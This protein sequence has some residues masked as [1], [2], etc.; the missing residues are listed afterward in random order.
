MPRLC[1]MTESNPLLRQPSHIRRFLIVVAILAA[2]LFVAVIM[3]SRGRPEWTP[4]DR[5]TSDT[6]VPAEFDDGRRHFTPETLTAR[7]LA[8]IT[9]ASQPVAG[10]L[11]WRVGV[12]IADG[13]PLYYDWPTPRPGWYLNWT[14]VPVKRGGFWGL[15]QTSAVALPAASL[16]MEY[17]PMVRMRNGRLFPD[18]DQLRIL[19][20]NS[21]GLTWL[22]GNEPDV[23]WQD[24]TSPEVYAIAYQRAYTA[25]KAGDPTAQVAIGGLSQITPLR[26]EYLDRVWAFYRKL[27]GTAMPVD[28]WNMHAFVLREARN[29]WGVN[30]PPGFEIVNRGQLWDVADHGNLALVEE[31]VRAMRRWM[32]EHGQQEKPLWISEYGILMP[33]EYG[34]TP[35]YVANFMAASFDLFEDLRDPATG[36]ATDDYRLV[37]RWNWYSARDSRFAAGN[38]FDDYGKPTVVGEAMSDYIVANGP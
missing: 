11:N 31:Q 38:L 5:V 34:F 16:G 9:P 12:G 13:N 19:A 36:L 10:S 35:E 6:L 8:S 24:N 30:I 27:Y 25:I 18:T 37:Q 17:T 33:A 29:S 32:A 3:A 2:L 26:L 28:L 14:V 1:V 7:P 15:W 20:E 21:P 22:I 23:V 4:A